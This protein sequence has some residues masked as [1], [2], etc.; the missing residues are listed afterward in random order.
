MGVAAQGGVELARGIT[1]FKIVGIDGA[2]AR[3]RV[4]IGSRT[5]CAA[6]YR[7]LIFSNYRVGLSQRDQSALHALN[8]DRL[9]RNDLLGQQAGRRH[10]A[11]CPLTHEQV[12][13]IAR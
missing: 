13:T 4:T 7:E 10:Q 11:V 3:G 12:K 1:I 6:Q 9:S 8:L 5:S 2:A